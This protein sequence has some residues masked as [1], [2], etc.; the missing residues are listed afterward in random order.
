MLALCHKNW[1]SFDLLCA[2]LP[3]PSLV[4]FDRCNGL[5][6]IGNWA[7]NVSYS[8]QVTRFNIWL[9]WFKFTTLSAAEDWD[10][11]YWIAEGSTIT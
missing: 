3:L 1:R 9:L 5:D 8:G 7:G 4:L 11:A 2:V 6:V 10:Q